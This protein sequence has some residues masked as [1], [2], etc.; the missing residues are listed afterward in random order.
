MSR[1]GREQYN[2]TTESVKPRLD[3]NNLLQRAKDQ[4]KTDKKNNLLI[5]SG[6]VTVAS[7]VILLLNI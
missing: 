4:K 7:A 3:L 5:L 6:A 2:E 1:F